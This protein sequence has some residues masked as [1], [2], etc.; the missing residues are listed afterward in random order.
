[1]LVLQ[2]E[3]CYLPLFPLGGCWLP[4]SPIDTIHFHIYHSP[5]RCWALYCV[6]LGF[7]KVE[8]KVLTLKELTI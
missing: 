4:A 8:D 3:I 6:L 5:I 1:M 7:S 2:T